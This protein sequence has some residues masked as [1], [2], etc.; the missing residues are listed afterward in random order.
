MYWIK[1]TEML[2][3]VVQKIEKCHRKWG[4]GI[5]ADGRI[6]AINQGQS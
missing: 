6:S 1:D 5:Q 4:E 3:L 2:I